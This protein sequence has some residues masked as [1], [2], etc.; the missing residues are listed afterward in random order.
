MADA[1]DVSRLAYT[2]VDG[3]VGS[4]TITRTVQ[5]SDAGQRSFDCQ[6]EE[7]AVMDL[8]DKRSVAC[9]QWVDVSDMTVFIEFCLTTCRTSCY[10]LNQALYICHPALRPT[11]HGKEPG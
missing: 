3:V 7:A 4:I 8:G 1:A 10:G 6:V 5:V 9:V 11:L 2:S